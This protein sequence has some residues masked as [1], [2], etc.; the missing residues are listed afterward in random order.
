MKKLLALLFTAGAL[1]AVQTSVIWDT[2]TGSIVSN[3]TDILLESEIDTD[4]KT[5]SLPASTTISTFGASL[6]DDADAGA[7]LSTLKLSN[8]VTYTVDPVN[9]DDTNGAAGGVPYLTFA[10]AMADLVV[11]APASA[12]V[13][14]KAG[15]YGVST[16]AYVTDTTDDVVLFFNAE[17]GVV[18][19]GSGILFDDS[20]NHLNVYGIYGA[21]SANAGAQ[22]FKI[23]TP[24]T[25]SDSGTIDVELRP[26]GFTAVAEPFLELLSGRAKVTS[27]NIV[28]TDESIR[29]DNFP[30]GVLQVS[31]GELT[32]ESSIISVMDNS[33][34]FLLPNSAVVVVESGAKA[35]IRDCI[36]N[37]AVAA[38]LKATDAELDLINTHGR[39]VSADNYLVEADSAGTDVTVFGVCSTNLPIDSDITLNDDYGVLLTNTSNGLGTLTGNQTWTGTNT[40]DD[41]VIDTFILPSSTIAELDAETTFET[42]ELRITENDHFVKATASDAYAYLP[43]QVANASTYYVDPASGDDSQAS[44]GG[45]PY[46][47]IQAAMDD[48]YA[49]APNLAVVHLRSGGYVA[50]E[51]ADIVYDP[52]N[53]GTLLYFY[54][55]SGVICNL[56]NGETLIDN[57]EDDFTQF[58]GIVGDITYNNS[59]SLFDG[60]VAGG[61]GT[62]EFSSEFNVKIRNLA[63][64]S[65]PVI[66][67]RSGEA[68]VNLENFDSAAAI[69]ETG[70]PNGIIYVDSGKVTIRDC[71]VTSANT[72]LF[73]KAG[74]LQI[75]SGAEGV[76][77][78]VKV[79]NIALAHQEATDASLVLF[80][81]VHYSARA[82]D[83]P[84][85]ADVASTDVNLRG[86]NY[87]NRAMGANTNTVTTFGTFSS[88]SDPSAILK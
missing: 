66:R 80:D 57:T 28:K 79:S 58:G 12:T 51:A 33:L 70:K 86:D 46:A 84:I 71:V 75:A 59:G 17:A 45:F 61:S 34:V 10:A 87:S 15:I 48:V 35:I 60:H 53:T 11:D 81:C 27:L 64:T 63:N 37:N 20:A 32:L 68:V 85:V 38:R 18:L 65:S 9:G 8:S 6:V 76:L 21:W 62:G 26:Y 50:T 19:T 23:N 78:N 40:F 39:Y 4:L 43:Y 16:H 22:Y 52:P 83:T 69:T 72:I 14:L 5:F 1:S 25:I 56:N 36:F 3:V 44:A 13:H 67:I 73:S 49:D 88:A 30:N 74:L 54:A 2:D 24:D 29:A 31:G 77:E 55:E 42:G 47:T 82:S 7:A 41:L